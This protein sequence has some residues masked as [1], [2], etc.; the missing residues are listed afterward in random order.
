MGTSCAIIEKKEDNSYRMITVHWDGY[1]DGAGKILFDNYNDETKLDSLFELGDLSI[2]GP[3]PISKPEWWDYSKPKTEEQENGCLSYSDRGDY[4]P[5]TIFSDYDNLLE[6][7]P[8]YVCF[9]YLF[10]EG[11]WYLAERVYAESKYYIRLTPL[12][13]VLNTYNKKEDE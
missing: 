12:S 10:K 9:T 6:D 11:E 7:F 13:I 1:P 2:L 5:P 4:C 8:T 3:N